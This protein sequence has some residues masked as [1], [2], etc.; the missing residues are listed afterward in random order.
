[1]TIFVSVF[2]ETNSEIEELAE[3]LFRESEPNLYPYV[4]V[5]LQRSTSSWSRLDDA[6]DPYVSF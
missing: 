1:M 2:Y 4:K 3:Q 6:D 5:N